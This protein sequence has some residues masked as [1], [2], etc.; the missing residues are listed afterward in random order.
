MPKSKVGNLRGG[1]GRTFGGILHTAGL[2]A[3]AI[4][5]LLVVGAVTGLVDLGGIFEGGTK[6]KSSKV[7]LKEIKNLST[8]TAAK[9]TYVVNVTQ[10][11]NIPVV[12]DFI[13]AEDITLRGVGT[14]DAGTDFSVLST[15]AVQVDDAGGVTIT[16]PPPVLGDAFV[17]PQRS[18][19]VNRSRGLINRI[20]DAIDGDSPTDDRELY[21]RAAVKIEKAAK[22]SNLSERAER[23][24]IEML[25]GFLA[26]LGFTD[27]RITFEKPAPKN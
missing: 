8:F 5:I 6:T 15:D 19:V 20:G 18:E 17:D 16:L 2:G 14:V 27:V 7:L 21:A 24:T 25:E 23:N 11:E 13:A 26:R 3:I 10:D 22:E 1:G 4:A 12:P 9:G